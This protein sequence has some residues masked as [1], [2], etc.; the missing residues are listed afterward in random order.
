MKICIGND[1]A[2][3]QL[4]NEIVEYFKENNIDYIDMGVAE[5]EKCDYPD[6]AA[7][8]C[9]KITDGECELGILVC[10]TG[11]GMSISANKIKGIRA[12][13]CSDIFS[14][15]YTRLHNDANVLCIG[16]RVVGAGLAKMLVD[17]F[18]NTSFEGGRH[19]RRVDKITA[20]EKK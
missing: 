17:E 12:A 5:G 9:E 16:A 4:K 3:P 20:L 14:V 19:Q 7:E 8:V 11:V 6:K 15:K 1:H 18:L 13:C 10:G 2:G